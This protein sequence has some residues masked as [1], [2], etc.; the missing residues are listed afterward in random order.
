MSLSLICKVDILKIQDPFFKQLRSSVFGKLQQLWN[1]QGS[2][3]VSSDIIM[4]F[5]GRLFVLKNDTRWNSEY[6][7]VSC[8][9]RLLKKSYRQMKKLF[10]E[11]NIDFISPHEEKI[12]KEYVRV[13]KSVCEALDVLQG[14][15][16]VGMGFLLPTLSVLKNKL[17]ALKDDASIIP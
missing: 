12:L 10:E 3:S 13:T 14:E 9:V 2:S 16:N 7:A 4:R 1:K 15:K 6:S 5:L 17:K 11:L 8:L